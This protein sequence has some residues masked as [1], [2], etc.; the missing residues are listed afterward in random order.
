MM[1]YILLRWSMRCLLGHVGARSKE[2]YV[3]TRICFNAKSLFR[4]GHLHDEAQRAIRRRDG[5]SRCCNMV[6]G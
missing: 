4:M 6:H 5:C 3:C 1:I 2:R